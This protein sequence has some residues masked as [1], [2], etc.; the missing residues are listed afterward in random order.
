MKAKPNAPKK[1]NVALVNVLKPNLL[2]LIF[3]PRRTRAHQSQSF[4]RGRA[5]EAGHALS[6]ASNAEPRARIDDSPKS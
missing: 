3:P 1:A 4:S 6:N 5:I 2:N